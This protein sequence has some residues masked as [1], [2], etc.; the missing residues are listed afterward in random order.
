[1]VH[2][3]RLPLGVALILVS[4]VVGVLSP[5]IIKM[6][7]EAAMERETLRDIGKLIALLVGS[8]GVSLVVGFFRNLIFGTMAESATR[9]LRCQFIEH[10]LRLPK[11]RQI[12]EFHFAA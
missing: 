11:I 10:V 9:D 7:V 8:L 12:M 4:A 3:T 5:Y 6:L 1:M 2:N